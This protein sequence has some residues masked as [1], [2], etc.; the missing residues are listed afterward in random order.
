MLSDERIGKFVAEIFGED[1]FRSAPGKYQLF[2]RAIE[3]AARDEALE[4]AIQ[5]C[6]RVDIIGADECIEKIR[7][8]KSQ[9]KE[10]R[11]AE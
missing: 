3:Q 11:D 6:D 10:N 5:A 8:L 4:E 9:S 2:A 7:A 1:R